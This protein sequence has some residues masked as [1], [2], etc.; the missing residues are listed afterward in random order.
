M[1]RAMP[2]PAHRGD[3]RDGYASAARRLRDAGLD[4]VEVVASHGYLP[5]QFLNPR[6]NLRDRPLRRQRREP[7]ALPARD[8]RRDPRRR[9]AGTPVVGLRISID[10]ITPDGLTPEDVLPALAALDAR[11]APRLRQRR[12]RDVGDTR[13]L[14]SHRAADDRAQRLHGAAGRPGQGR[15]VGA[16]HGRR[17]D[18]PAA[19][20]RAHPRARPGRRVRHDPR[21]DLRPAAAGQGRRRPDRRDPG[22]RRLQPGLHRALPRRLSDLV[23]PVP[24]ERPRARV[25][26]ARAG[27]A[28][29]RRDGGRR[30]PGRAQGRHRRR[31]A[32]PPGDPL[33]GR[34]P[35]R[36]PGPARRAAARSRRVRRRRHQPRRRG[37]AGRGPDRDRDRRRPR[38]RRAASSPTSS[39]SR[40]VPGRAGRRSS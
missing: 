2:D 24:G 17:A 12:R 10:E 21:A 3:R 34:S 35:G 31:R 37:R 13:R 40:R 39:S 11:R 9:S 20:G 38:P 6:V 19:G 22:L 29:P 14:R 15:R 28:R 36:R 32:R 27:D 8:D 1:P 16:G 5:A 26:P 33:R 23:H 18:Q 30:W 25:R 7:P 4:G